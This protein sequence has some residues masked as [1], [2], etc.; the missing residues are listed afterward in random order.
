ML[1]EKLEFEVFLLLNQDLLAVHDVDALLHLLETLASKVVDALELRLFVID[2]LDANLAVLVVVTISLVV[3]NN[4]R[5]VEEDR[6]RIDKE[7]LVPVDCLL[8]AVQLVADFA[9]CQ[10][11]FIDSLSCN[12]VIAAG[13]GSTACKHVVVLELGVS[14]SAQATYEGTTILGRTFRNL[15]FTYIEAV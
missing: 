1:T 4:Q 14:M 9:A 7:R 13:V 5:G 8:V 10:L 12:L 3:E 11:L 6:I 15:Y 2:I